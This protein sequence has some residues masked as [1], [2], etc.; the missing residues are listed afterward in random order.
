VAA[1]D[2]KVHAVGGRL[3]SF[4]RNL[5]VHEVYDPATDRWSSGPALP[6]ARSGVA[7]VVAGGRLLVLGG[8]GSDG[9]FPENEGFDPASGKWTSYAG[10]PTARHGIGA[11]EVGGVVYVPS[12]GPTP[13]GSQT[14]VHEAFTIEPAR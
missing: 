6:T 12:G 8:E 13:G 2:G 9:T 10:M 3:G 7:A 14:P 4:A 5:D 1:I 11:A